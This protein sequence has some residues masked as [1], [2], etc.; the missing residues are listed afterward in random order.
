MA[1]LL[2]LV[3]INTGH[4]K[5]PKQALSTC[6]SVHRCHN[7]ELATCISQR[8][9]K[10]QD[11]PGKLPFVSETLVACGVVYQGVDTLSAVESSNLTKVVDQSE[12]IPAHCVIKV[13]KLY[14]F[15]LH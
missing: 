3:K 1:I 11:W 7:T 4:L 15:V 13:L 8:Q 10:C 6:F 9:G 5:Q 12:P 2:N 14:L